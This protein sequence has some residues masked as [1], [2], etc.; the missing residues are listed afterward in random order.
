MIYV[1][2][3]ACENIKTNG[4]L[5]FKHLIM[6]RTKQILMVSATVVG[7]CLAT[8]AIMYHYMKKYDENSNDT[9]LQNEYAMPTGYTPVSQRAIETDFTQAAENTVN[10]VVSI[11]TLT[12]TAQ[13]A[14]RF[15]DPF[16]EFFFGPGRVQPQPQ[17]RA[18]LGSG[19]IISPD[20]Y[21][22]T[23][24]HV[25]SG[26]DKIEVTLNDNRSFN[27]RIIGTDPNTDLALIK[28]EAEGLPVVQFGN[29]D[30]LKVGEWVLA[31]GN[32]FGLTSTVTAGIV[33]AKARRISDNM[34]NQMGIESF[35]Q[36][37]AAVNPGNSGGALVNTNGELVGINTAI[38]SET[39]NYAGYSF[40]IPSSIVS[41]VIADLRQYGTVQ[42]AVMGIG[43]QEI[44]SAMAKEKGIN[45]LEGVYVGEVYDL[46]AAMEAGIEV[47]DIVTA[48]NG[49][50]IKNGAALQEQISRYRPG[51]KIKV[52]IRR[53]NKELEKSLT[54]RNSQGSTEMKKAVGFGSLGTSFKDLTRQQMQEMNIRSGVQVVGLKDGKFKDAGIRE[55]FVIL[56][57][58]GQNIRS[59]NDMESIFDSIVRSNQTRKVMFITGIYPTGKIMYYAVDLSE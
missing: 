53:N 38:F 1:L 44:T 28:I 49:V 25:I 42:R 30:D 35:I 7:T 33:S 26:A 34:T 32:P 48:I 4:H 31:V 59:V 47:G 36:T 15:N 9:Y 10:A 57:V 11:R 12:A 21:I 50:K 23:N 2:I 54:L 52:S 45:V 19:V 41:K 13:S 37:D 18:G 8:S 56:E 5:T 58:N 14:G 3:L 46:S 29:S 16:L 55:G 27:G 22:V 6:N 24:N 40:A 39:G 17:P 20:G 43:F 51:D